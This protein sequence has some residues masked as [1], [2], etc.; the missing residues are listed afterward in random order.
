MNSNAL[1]LAILSVLICPLAARSAQIDKGPPRLFVPY[2]DL[3]AVVDPAAKTVL[4]ER[5]AF[6]QLLGAVWTG[7]SDELPPA[8]LDAAIIF[9]DILLPLEGMGI[10][11][12]FAG[13]RI[14]RLRHEQSC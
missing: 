13:N 7:G 1:K 3:A 4:M 10:G 12:E 14:R 5:Q 6:A 11:L 8:E 9:G 2:R